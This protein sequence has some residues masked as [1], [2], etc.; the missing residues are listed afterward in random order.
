MI[1]SVTMQTLAELSSD[2]IKV[3]GRDLSTD[4]I[5]SIFIY[6]NGA[7]SDLADDLADEISSHVAD[8]DRGRDAYEVARNIEK[9]EV[10]LSHLCDSETKLERVCCT[11]KMAS[12]PAICS[13]C[14]KLS[15]VLCLISEIARLS[16]WITR[17]TRRRS[18]LLPL[19][20]RISGSYRN[21]S[22]VKMALRGIKRIISEFIDASRR[23]E[24]GIYLPTGEL[25]IGYHLRN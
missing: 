22:G 8:L 1:Y 24:L 11:V 21:R 20:L 6:C 3:V 14:D 7:S 10:L 16:A 23:V 19:Q 9:V 25:F 15:R 2:A 5:S 4:K 13:D 18:F 17:D 12:L